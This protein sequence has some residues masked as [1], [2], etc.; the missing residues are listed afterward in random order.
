MKNTF[1]RTPGRSA[2]TFTCICCGHRTRNTGVQSLGSEL[3]PP[4]YELAGI[5]NEISDGFAT[6][7]ELR[8]EIDKLLTAVELQGGSLDQWEGLR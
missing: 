1:R 4:C 6:I 2:Q 3:C 7:E 5:E 8:S